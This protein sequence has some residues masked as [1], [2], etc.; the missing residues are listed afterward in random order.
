MKITMYGSHLCQN[1]I[2]GISKLKDYD[3]EID[4]R[5]ISS[6]FKAL[7]EFMAYRESDEIFNYAKENDKIG[8]PFFIY[9]NGEKTFDFKE[10]IEKIQF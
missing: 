2:Y 6:D 4:F 9:E 8:I 3:V 1:V 10:I 7:K 5:N